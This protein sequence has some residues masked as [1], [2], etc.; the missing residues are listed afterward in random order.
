[1]IETMPEGVARSHQVY[2]AAFFR[3]S[4]QLD[5]ADRL[6]LDGV[7]VLEQDL[8]KWPRNPLTHAELANYYGLLGDVNR[9]S[10]EETVLARDYGADGEAVMLSAEGV[11]ARGDTAHLVEAL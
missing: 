10:D 2:A 5:R 9:R 6:L 4:G 8:S 7:D 3:R 11:A 1:M